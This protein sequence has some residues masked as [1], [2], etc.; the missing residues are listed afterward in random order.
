MSTTPTEQH[1]AALAK[2]KAALAL[3]K[4][5]KANGP[6]P[7]EEELAALLDQSLDEQRRDAIMGHI[8]NTPEVYDQWIALVESIHIEEAHTA[9]SPLMAANRLEQPTGLATTAIR[10]WFKDVLAGFK[11][12]SSLKAGG[13]FAVAAVVAVAVLQPFGGTNYNYEVDALFEQYGQQW[14]AIPTQATTLDTRGAVLFPQPLT[15]EQHTVKQAMQAAVGTMRLNTPQANDKHFLIAA[16]DNAPTSPSE[17]AADDNLSSTEQQA[18]TAIG[19]IAAI[20]HFKC[21]QN[22]AD[23][24]YNK[25]DPLLRRSAQQLK[26]SS[27]PATAELAENLQLNTDAKD[28]ICQGAA[29]VIGYIKPRPKS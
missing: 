11:V 2:V 13:T 8:A 12:N 9:A 18:L 27:D 10:G 20:A 14:E 19:R 17:A 24:F 1:Y 7:T 28:N 21:Q 25:A 5:D 22:T 23:G 29:T 16:L 3:A 6:V 26:K 15:V 4:L